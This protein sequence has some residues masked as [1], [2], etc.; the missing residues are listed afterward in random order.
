MTGMIPREYIE[1]FEN[2]IYLPMVIKIFR[3]D[4]QHFQTGAFKLKG[5]YLELVEA[6]C[7]IAESEYRETKEYMR[8]KK[9]KLE[10]GEHDD[11]ATMY[12]FYHDGF[13]SRRKY[14]NVRLRNRTEELIGVYL[15]QA[16]NIE[17]PSAD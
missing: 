4:H 5:P 8:K 7:K 12:I 17:K 10:T 1:H 13:T 14:L 15:Q 6:A 3:Q 11:F 9:L 16:A 2:M